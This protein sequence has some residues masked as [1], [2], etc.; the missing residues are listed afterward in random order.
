[1]I[2]LILLVIIPSAYDLFGCND[3]ASKVPNYAV[4]RE[5][6]FSSYGFTRTDSGLVS[7]DGSVFYG[8]M[9]IRQK[10][11]LGCVC[12]SFLNRQLITGYNYSQYILWILR[13]NRFG[14]LFLKLIVWVADFLSCLNTVQ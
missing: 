7:K 8:Y 2:V 1:L 4:E 10:E 3:I 13:Q 5:K 14:F 9:R 12:Y 6:A 11:A